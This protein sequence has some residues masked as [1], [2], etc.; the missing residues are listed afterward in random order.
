MI[1]VLS[2]WVTVFPPPGKALRNWLGLG[3]CLPLGEDSYRRD[4]I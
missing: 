3:M 4:V 1:S 2:S